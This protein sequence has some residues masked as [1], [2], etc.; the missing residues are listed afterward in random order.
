MSKIAVILHAEPGTHDSMGRALHALLYTKELKEHGHNVILVFDGGATKWIAEFKKK[1]N[2]L[3]PLYNDIIGS[4]VILGVCEYC[5][6]AFGG[7]KEQIK[8]E[9]IPLLNDYNGHPSLADF[10]DQGYQIITL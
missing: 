1:D 2:K 5:I 4:E 9:G 3:A 8:N 10:I 6:G 7:D